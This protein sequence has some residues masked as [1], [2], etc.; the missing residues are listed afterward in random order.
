MADSA[1]WHGTCYIEG[2]ATVFFIPPFS[3]KHLGK[4]PGCFFISP[5]SVYGVHGKNHAHDVN[6]VQRNPG[7]TQKT[8]TFFQK[9]QI[10]PTVS[11]YRFLSIVEEQVVDF[12]LTPYMTPHYNVEGESEDEN[13]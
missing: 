10:F 12:D 6:Q 2:R 4:N 8:I 3:V 9:T 5:G 1:T 13:S 11:S 7:D